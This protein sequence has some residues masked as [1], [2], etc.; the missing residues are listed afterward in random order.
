MFIAPQ[1]IGRFAAEAFDHPETWL[2]R[3]EAIAGQRLSYAEAAAAMSR[4][5]GHPVTYE[6]IP[7]DEF[8]ATAAPT[9]VAREAWYLENSDPVDVD[10]LQAQYPWLM[11]LEE[12]LRAEGWGTTD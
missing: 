3:E 7:W 9:A 4:V 5:L 1:D 8:T 11:T 6:P 12:Y 2:G 10:R